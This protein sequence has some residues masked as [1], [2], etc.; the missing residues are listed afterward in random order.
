MGRRVGQEEG[1]GRWE[2]VGLVEGVGPVREQRHH[3]TARLRP[4]PD[5][6]GPPERASEGE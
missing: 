1:G 6:H 4:P 2:S 5:R 3:R